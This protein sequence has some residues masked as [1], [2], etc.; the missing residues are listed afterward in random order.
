MTISPTQIGQTVGAIAGSAIAP[1]V[2]TQLGSLAGIL[3]GMVAQGQIDK[4]TEKKERRT[5]GE[6]MA[7]GSQAPAAAGE[8]PVGPLALVWVDETVIDGRVI[9]GR[10]ES[11]HLP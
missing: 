7:N 1:G 6:Q 9:A 3:A 8:T 4:A 11:R 5:L 2:G 10:F